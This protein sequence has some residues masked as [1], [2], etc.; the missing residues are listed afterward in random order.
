MVPTGQA[1]AP[2]GSMLL[3]AYDRT[4]EPFIFDPHLQYFRSFNPGWG[5]AGPGLTSFSGQFQEFSWADQ[6][7]DALVSIFDFASVAGCFGAAAQ[8]P[9]CTA[10]NYGYWLKGAFHPGTPAV[11]STELFIVADHFDDTWVGPFAW[12][13]LANIVPFTP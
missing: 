1:V 6:N 11:V 8:T 4:G 12:G 10:P 9:S 13:G 3:Q 7:D 5:L 2:E